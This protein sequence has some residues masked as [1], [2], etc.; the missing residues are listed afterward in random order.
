MK[1]IKLW[2][3]KGYFLMDYGGAQMGTKALEVR[4]GE[5]Y[6]VFDYEGARKAQRLVKLN[7]G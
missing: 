4:T 6:V 7:N 2:G 3:W 1:L 5:T